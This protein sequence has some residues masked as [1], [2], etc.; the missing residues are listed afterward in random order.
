[1]L[2]LRDEGLERVGHISGLRIVRLRLSKS[3]DVFARTKSTVLRIWEVKAEWF[4]LSAN[5]L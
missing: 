5:S 1:M 3:M 2:N 4:K